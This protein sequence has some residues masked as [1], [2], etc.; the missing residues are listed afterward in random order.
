MVCNSRGGRRKHR[1]RLSIIAEILKGAKEGSLRTQITYKAGLSSAQLRDFLPVL[2]DSNL[3]EVNEIAKNTIYKT[4]NK[5]LRYL[6]H[7]TEIGELL[8]KTRTRLNIKEGELVVVTY[9]SAVD[10]MKVFS[11]FIREGLENGDLVDYAYPDEESETVR[12]TLKEHGIDVEKYERQGALVLNGLSEWYMP[13]GKFDKERA[14]KMEFE[15]RA[16]AKR[17]GYKHYRALEDVGDFSFLN[18]QWQIYTDYWDNPIWVIPSGTYTELLNY[19][20]FVIELNAFNVEGIGEAQLAEMFKAFW[21]GNPA[22]TV[23]IDLLEY[24]NAFS[25]LLNMSHN[26]LI[27]RKILLEF[28]PTSEYEKIVNRLANEAIANVS[29]VFIFTTPKSIIHSSLAKQPAV[30]FFLLS[31]STPT[32]KSKA[33]NEVI[34]PAKNMVSLKNTL[35]KVL[36]EYALTNVFLVFDKLSELINLVGFDK[37]YKFLI[38]VIEMLPQTKATAIFLLNKGAHEPQVVSRIRGLFHNLLTYDKDEI[39]VAK[40]SKARE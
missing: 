31:T 19:T 10:K 12:A 8:K 24:T 29:P 14:F 39:K 33:E 7:Y 16:E 17:K 4:T 18:G 9:T 28:D 2:L 35:N 32:P 20:P 15:A 26:K 6:Q 5:G 23:F 1:D 22:Y 37:T 13:D 30:K 11:A 27:G 34:L 40:L 38:D 25:K 36:D 3:I 21:V